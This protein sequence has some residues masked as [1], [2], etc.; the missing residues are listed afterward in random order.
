MNVTSQSGCEAISVDRVKEYVNDELS[1]PL[2][3]SAGPCL[4]KSAGL[5]A[6]IEASS[7]HGE[8]ARPQTAEPAE[9]IQGVRERRRH[10]NDSFK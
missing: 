5:P 8:R 9:P 3:S 7:S 4:N 1:P 2:L 10:L 6:L